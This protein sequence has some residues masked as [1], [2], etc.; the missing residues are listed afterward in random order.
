MGKE[1][2]VRICPQ[3]QSKEVSFRGMISRQ[4]LSPNYVCLTCGFQGPLFP[5]IKEEDA[6]KLPEQTRNFVQSQ[7]PPVS[8]VSKWV[9]ITMI[10]III[11]VFILSFLKI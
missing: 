1:K 10:A 3:C 8:K 7:L 11:L 6:K 4:A 2:L 9:A 5:Q